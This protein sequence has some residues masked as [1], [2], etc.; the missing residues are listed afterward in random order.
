MTN[1]ELS[2]INDIDVIELTNKY[3][4]PFAQQRLV[5]NIEEVLTSAKEI[6]YPVTMKL[7][8]E[9]ITHKS[10]FGLVITNI[11]DENT[12]KISLKKMIKK[13]QNLKINGFLVQKHIT[14]RRELIVG[15]LKHEHYGPCVY[16]G[17]GGIV[18]EA[19]EDVAFR[20]V[21]I[22]MIDLEEMV[23]SLKCSKILGN[24]RGEPPINKESLFSLMKSIE[25][26]L[27]N[28]PLI[29]QIEFNPVIIQEDLPIAVDV[30]AYRH[31]NKGNYHLSTTNKSFESFD[32]SSLRN[33]FEPKSIA[34]VGI[35]DSPLKWGFR[36]LFNTLEGKYKGKIYGVNPKR[37]EVLGIPC[38]PSIKDLPEPVDLVVIIVPP[39]GVISSIEDCI[40]KNIKNIL[41]ITAGFGELPLEEAKKSQERLVQLAEENQ[42]C[43]IGP[44]CAGVVSPTPMNLY[45]SMIGRFPSDGKLSILSQSGNIGATI[46]SWAQEHSLG[47]AHFISTGNEA[48]V[49]NFHYLNYFNLDKTTKTIFAYIESEKNIKLFFDSLKKVSKNTPVIVFKGGKTEAGNKA[50]SSHTGALATNYRLFKHLCLQHGGILVEDIYE[51]IETAHLLLNVPLPKG[52]NVG[53][54]SQGGGWGVITADACTN[55]GLNVVPLSEETM[56]KLDSIMPGWWNR[57]NPVDMVAGTDIDL[58]KNALEIM[59]KAPEV[60]ILVIL[61][62]GYVAQSIPRFQ[63][64]ALA[65]SLGL[66]KLSDIGLKIEMRDAEF[67]CQ[68][69]R[70]TQKTVAIASDTTILSRG[71][72]PNPVIK[73]LEEMGLYVFQSPNSMARA[74][75][76][77]CRYSEYL[78]NIPRKF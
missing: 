64:S 63:K 48:V 26:L 77:L 75:A 67:I 25:T 50:A 36:V 30:L 52:R 38:Y 29:A 61:G 33:V 39:A 19:L 51:G 14:G 24:F 40:K 2:I 47:I 31:N 70:E 73:K 20:S 54:L 12:L 60:D 21:P 46:M 72:F 18:V 6:G 74:L 28:E 76:N 1:K 16:I 9:G 59:I 10:D 62:V 3:Q 8:A 69:M 56:K 27:S 66:D 11:M 57:N 43:L 65:Q 34:I 15:G 49:R 44:N 71:S 58:F 4:I 41:V 7:L 68:L 32:I 55:E 42:L 45:C 23:L 5:G 13:S 78:M 17:I 35:T 37:Q 22:S 53:I